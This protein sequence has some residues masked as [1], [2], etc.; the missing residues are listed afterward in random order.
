MAD[1]AQY[2]WRVCA[3]HHVCCNNELGGR[4]QV[5]CLVIKR[6]IIPRTLSAGGWHRTPVSLHDGFP[7]VFSLFSLIVPGPQLPQLPPFS[8]SAASV[9]Y[10][11]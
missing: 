2:Q 3:L 5:Q 9:L 10:H 1:R 6:K 8:L 4:A 7:L 11:I